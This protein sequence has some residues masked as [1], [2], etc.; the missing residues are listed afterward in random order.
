MVNYLYP[1][2]PPQNLLGI[3]LILY[4]A[5]TLSGTGAYYNVLVIPIYLASFLSSFEVY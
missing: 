4:T 3:F 1:A 2:D 5:I